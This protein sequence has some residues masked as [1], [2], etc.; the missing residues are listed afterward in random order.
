MF[1][2]NTLKTDKYFQRKALSWIFDRVPTS[3]GL[4]SHSLFILGI[5][6]SLEVYILVKTMVMGTKR[7][8]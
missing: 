1:W 6:L 5:I 7:S 2:S 8:I 3:L 4:Y